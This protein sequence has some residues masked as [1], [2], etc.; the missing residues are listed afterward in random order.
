MFYSIKIDIAMEAEGNSMSDRI[1]YSR[2]A[3]MRAQQ[4]RVTAILVFLAFGVVIGSAIALLFAPQ[5]GQNTRQRIAH[6]LEDGF[7][8]GL[9]S[10]AE[11]VRRLEKDFGDLRRRVERNIADRN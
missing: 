9:E 11:T 2:E 4:E 1:Y 5:S 10:T 3:E 6:S 7:G 8:E